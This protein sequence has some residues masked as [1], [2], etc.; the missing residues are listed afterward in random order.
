MDAVADYLEMP[1]VA[2]YEVAGFYS[3]YA[4]KPV[5]R[6]VL[7]V[8]TNIS[9]ALRGSEAIVKHLEHRLGIG[10]GETTPDGTF[11]L[12]EVEC[13]AACGGAPA[14][15]VGKRYYENLTPERL[16]AILQELSP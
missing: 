12:Q 2:V 9:C 4:L 7:S 8:C 3:M 16:D 6:H 10:L 5:G 1:R 11:T 14:M 13:L 15:M